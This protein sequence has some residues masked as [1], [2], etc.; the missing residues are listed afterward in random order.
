MRTIYGASVLGFGLLMSACGGGGDAT[1]PAEAPP[2]PTVTPATPPMADPAPVAA[3]P[4]AS[5]KP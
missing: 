4:P 5:P 3:T 2:A 1:K